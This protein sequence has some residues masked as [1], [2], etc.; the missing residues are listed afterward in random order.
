VQPTWQAICGNC[1]SFNEIT[2][3]APPKVAR[4]TAPPADDG[5]V[6]TAEETPPTQLAVTSDSK[7]GS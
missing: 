6:V 7:P 4:L 1:G 2:W 5:T 3:K